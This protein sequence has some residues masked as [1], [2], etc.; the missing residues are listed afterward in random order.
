M[1]WAAPAGKHAKP[2][3][4][5]VLLVVFDQLRGDYLSRWGDLFGEGGFRR[6]Q[7]EGAWYTN[8]HYPYADTKTGPGHASLATGCVPAEHGIV[9]NDWFDRRIGKSAYCVETD[10]YHRVPNL[11]AK[12]TLLKTRPTG[13]VSPER[14]LVP[15]F[16]DLLKQATGGRAK[17]VSLSFKDRSAVLMGGAHPDACYWID[18]NTGEV[19]TSNYYR[20]AVHRWVAEF[21][22]PRP[23][24]RWTGQTWTPLHPELD[25]A[26]R[27]GLKASGSSGASAS[28]HFSHPFP[29]A[30]GKLYY[31]ALYTSPFGNDLVLG[32]AKQA[33]DAEALGQHEVPDLLSVSFSSNDAIGHMRGPDSPE[34]LD[35]TLRSDRIVKELLAHLDARVGP[36]N[37]LLALSA[38]HGVCPLPEV[39][40]ARGHEA[41]RVSTKL[42]S[43]GAENFLRATYGPAAKARYVEGSGEPWIYLNRAL[44]AQRQLN[45]VEVQQTLARWLEQQPG[46]WKAYTRTQ[47]QGSTDNDPHLS[48]LRRSFHPERCGDVGVILKPYHL[49]TSLTLNTTHG[50]PHEYDTHVPLLFLGPGIRAGTFEERIAPQAIAALFAR[51]LGIAPPHGSQAIIPA[52]QAASATLTTGR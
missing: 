9:A 41:A 50:T 25:Y 51:S 52:S 48:M 11:P 20:D 4:K 22:R 31:T 38:D 6:L 28:G 24:D 13:A 37:Y 12:R 45:P 44:L 43:L 2:P 39:S 40:L 42:L 49:F 17:V 1:P 26:A 34:V 27:C 8:C 46:I 21:N 16:G 19:I 14:L 36:G 15:T 35:V 10:R 29:A 47:L 3:I 33:I 5:L 7:H 18:P 30:P 23:A 32:L